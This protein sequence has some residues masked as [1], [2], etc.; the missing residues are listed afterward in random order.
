ML[1][2]LLSI[3]LIL[4]IPTAALSA[5]VHS[6]TNKATPTTSDE[7]P[8]EDAAASWGSKKTTLGALPISSAVSTA[9]GNKADAS[10]FASES[11]FNA[12]F[13]LTWASGTF[14][15]AGSYTLTGSWNFSGATVTG[16]SGGSMVYPG[17]G[18]PNSTGSAWGTS[19]T[20]G[21]AANNLIKLNSSGQLPFT[22]DVSDL[23]DTDGLF[24]A[25]ANASC[26]E[27]ESAFNACFP[28][29]W[30]TGGATN[31]DGLSDVV[32]SGTPTTNY[33]LKFNGTNWV[34]A[35]DATAEGAGYVSTPPTYSDE[36]CTNG[37][38]ALDASYRYDCLSNTWSRTSRTS[39]SNPQPVA[40]TLTSRVIGTN[41]TTLTLTGSASLS[42]GAGGNGGFDVDCS[43]AGNGITATYSSGSPGT[44]LVYTLGTTVNSGD[45]CDLD[46][47][48]PGNGIEATTGG[49]DLASISSAA[50]TNNST[51]TSGN[52][53]TFVNSA[54]GGNTVSLSNVASG[55]LIVV[56]VTWT[57]SNAAT[58]SVSDGTDTLTA[59]SGTFDAYTNYRYTQLFYL[60]SS[61][62]GNKTYTPTISGGDNISMT[63]WEFSHTSPVTVDASNHATG[64]TATVSSGNI[65]TTI[66]SG[67]VI[68]GASNRT[69]GG[70]SYPDI[71]GVTATSGTT[72]NAAMAYWNSS[73]YRI[74]SSTATGDAVWPSG[75]TGDV[76]Q[77]SVVAFK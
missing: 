20:V 45:T 39:W 37:Q 55:N 28:L 32:I 49:A 3:L 42:V 60:P 23:T 51:Q 63:V 31:L 50:I 6:R 2:S 48:Q 58:A 65:T 54:G 35:A 22:I 25:K 70:F 74:L 10:C 44:D 18:V 16:L 17:A 4:A 24:T 62:S 21:T 59:I 7:I 52:T 71:F 67:L 9:L 8:I 46:Y 1:K 41:G 61:S 68:T 72:I 33:V 56:Y 69:G 53:F 76:L 29:T 77:V 36:A 30:A 64:T 26:F 57:G 5:T 73:S 27:S 19:Y 15:Q 38:Y 34:P 43:T 13:D 12:C 40:P 75:S 47:T 11:A 66:P 14:D